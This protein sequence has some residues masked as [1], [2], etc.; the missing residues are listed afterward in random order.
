[1]PSV[2]S[3]EQHQYYGKPQNAFWRIMG[4]LFGACPDLP[5]DQRI[6]LL[7]S[8]GVAVWDVLES[9]VRPGSLD[10]AIDMKTVETN[11]IPGLLHAYPGICHLFFN[12]KKAEEIF[13]RRLLTTI[14]EA[15]PDISYCG[16]PSTSPAM[17]TLDFAGKLQQWR[18]IAA[19]LKTS[20]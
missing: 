10:S 7:A 11:D 15:R 14:C 2:A 1:M 4:E 20:S 13:R 5:Y 12:G 18:Q 17:A 3:L 19:R 9:C 16:L 8:K 6:E